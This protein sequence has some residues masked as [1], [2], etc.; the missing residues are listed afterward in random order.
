MEAAGLGASAVTNAD[1]HQAGP[2]CDGY[3]QHWHDIDGQIHWQPWR[4]PATGRPPPEAPLLP[5]LE[6]TFRASGVVPINRGPLTDTERGALG[7]YMRDVAD[8]MGLRD[9]RLELEHDEPE[10]AHGGQRTIAVVT[11]E[12]GRR[13]AYVSVRGRIRD[14]PPAVVRH[15]VTHELAHLPLEPL[16]QLLE[17]SVG[18]AIGTHAWLQLETA[19]RLLLEEAVDHLAETISAHM[20]EFPGW[21]PA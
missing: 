4:D 18:P 7:R 11:K 10:Q 12:Y 21:Q 16:L 3:V 6:W 5:P 1:T 14:E 19:H 15:V 9:W 13:I 8:R 20:P 17:E 2:D